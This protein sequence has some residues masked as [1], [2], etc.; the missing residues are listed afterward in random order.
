[1]KRTRHIRRSPSWPISFRHTGWS[2][3]RTLRLGTPTTAGPSRRNTRGQG[4]NGIS[5]ACDRLADSAYQPE[6]EHSVVNP[7]LTD[8]VPM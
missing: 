8:P 3:V 4:A 2:R 7:E 5:L 6:P 1:M